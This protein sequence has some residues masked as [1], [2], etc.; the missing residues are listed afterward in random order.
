MHPASVMAEYQTESWVK[1]YSLK[2]FLFY[3]YQQRDSWLHRLINPFIQWT[4]EQKG[5]ELDF[6]DVFSK[7][8]MTSLFVLGS[9]KFGE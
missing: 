7:I 1:N 6:W 4:K 9:L 2:E 8:R 3:C 5:F